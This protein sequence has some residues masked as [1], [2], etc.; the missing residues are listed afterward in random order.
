MQQKETIPDEP[1]LINLKKTIRSLE[2]EN[3]IL[4]LVLEY[5]DREIATHLDK[6]QKVLSSFSWRITLPLRKI[7]DAS[8]AIVK[9]HGSKA[10]PFIYISTLIRSDKILSGFTRADFKKVRCSLNRDTATDYLIFP[11]I[12]WDFRFQ[13]PQQIATRIA[14]K[15]NRVFY[16]KTS[17]NVHRENILP[18]HLAVRKISGNIFEI[19]LTC[20][21]NINLYKEDFD[22][23]EVLSGILESIE[24]VKRLF[25]IQHTVSLV[26]HP[27]WW[28]V[29][30]HLQ[31]NRT[32]YDC[33]DEHSGFSNNYATTL[34]IEYE[35]TQKADLVISS[36]TEL[37]N[38]NSSLN[39]NTFLCRNGA[40][41]DHFSGSTDSDKL[42][43]FPH[44]IIGYYGAI[45]EWFDIDLVEECARHYETY[46][47]VLIGHI[48]DL[49]IKGISGLT[50]VHFLKEIPYKKLPLYLNSFDV[51][52]IPFKLNKLT[53]ATNPVKFYE[54]LSA[55]KP[56]VTVALPELLEFRD[57]CYF[58]HSRQ[59]FINNIE[60]AV[61]EN[62]GK[63]HQRIQ[64]AKANSWDL[65]VNQIKEKIVDLY[66][67]VSIIIVTYN[68][69]KY[70]KECISSIY[71]YSRYPRF[72]LI[73]VDNNSSDG[74]VEF[75]DELT[76][77]K[78][79]F[80][81]IKNNANLGF[82]K[83]NN[84]GLKMA[85]GEYIIFLNNDTIVTND[86]I[87]T[88]LE[89]FRKD[90][91]LGLLCPVTNEIGNEVKIDVSIKIPK[92]IQEFACY[93]A[94]TSSSAPRAIK[95]APLFCVMTKKLLI[96]KFGG[97]CEDYHVGMFEDD[98]LSMQYKRSGYKI[99]CAED[100]FIY[101]I[102][103][104]SFKKLSDSEYL[105]IFNKNKAIFESKWGNW[106][107]HNQK[108]FKN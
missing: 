90:S 50:N 4:R 38:K 13:R 2:E 94:M 92:E 105:Q 7:A 67:L 43:D 34:S 30:K 25:A 18:R 17:F 48:S 70:T 14:G 96:D 75:L 91:H 68:N 65:R 61:N 84:M 24:C 36:S 81:L 21:K 31:N 87:V 86:W 97:L 9:P 72:E 16:F 39:R 101:H 59:D 80:H 82:A 35:L 27:S 88:L 41:F 64:L 32:V 74:S 19:G 98:D 1:E 85:Q 33:M 6:I 78:D 79:N 53:K 52:L 22:N 15:G 49:D 93:Y 5:K 56:V 26:D 106:I 37:L 60:K 58:S 83:A 47:F 51:C 102:G 20:R 100:V 42:S 62:N 95:I 57:N 29:V 99:C 28:P 40:D 66:P 44:P 55:G 23:P 12:D 46:H 3:K 76:V 69:I 108:A 71:K 54:Y 45:A 104:G 10:N 89:H 8:I 11:I 77:K 107:P 103:S 63:I 73:V